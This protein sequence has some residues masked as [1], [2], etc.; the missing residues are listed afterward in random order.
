MF[1]CCQSVQYSSHKAP[2]F[3]FVTSDAAMSK[4][5]NQKKSQS[6]LCWLQMCEKK[7]FVQ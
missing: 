1:K 7:E 3:H 5:G 6:D 4:Q 2:V